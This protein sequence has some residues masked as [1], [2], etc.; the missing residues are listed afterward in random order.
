MAIAYAEFDLKTVVQKLGLTKDEN[1]DLFA[2][3]D[4][5]EPSDFLRVW[6][7]RFVARVG[8]PPIER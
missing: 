4:P 8:V 2:R 1:T 7:D 6:L 5:I 3:I